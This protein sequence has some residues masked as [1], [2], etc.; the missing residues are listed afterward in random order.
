MVPAAGSIVI[1]QSLQAGI[2]RWQRLPPL[3][4]NDLG[5]PITGKLARF[6][7]TTALSQPL[8]PCSLT[9][10]HAGWKYPRILGVSAPGLP[11]TCGEDGQATSI[12]LRNDRLWFEKW[13]SPPNTSNE[14]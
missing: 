10:L 8:R 4:R 9:Q 1:R 12:P 11:E 14:D 6:S 7:A 3:A 5:G 13:V 2:Y